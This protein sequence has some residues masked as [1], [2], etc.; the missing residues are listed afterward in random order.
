MFLFVFIFHHT[1]M[2]YINTTIN[3]GNNIIVFDYKKILK[4][5]EA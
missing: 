2:V 1:M 3:L 5:P 4:T